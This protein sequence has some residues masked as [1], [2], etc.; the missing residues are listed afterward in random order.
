MPEIISAI[1]FPDR[2]IQDQSFLDADAAAGQ[3]VV[4]VND[5][6][7]WAVNDY[8]VIGTLGQE[9]A[10]L[11][12]V[13]SKSG[14]NV[15]LADNLI[16]KHF[17]NEPATRL[18][19]NQ[20]NFYAALAPLDNTPPA[21]AA[22]TLIDGPTDITAD[23]SFTNFTYTLGGSA[24]WYKYVFFNEEQGTAGALVDAEAVRGGNFGH[25]TTPEAVRK[26]AGLTGNTYIDNGEIMEAIEDAEGTIKASIAIGGYALPLRDD[27]AY[28]LA[29]K[30]T[31][32]MAAGY[33]LTSNNTNGYADVYKQGQDKMKQAQDICDAFEAGTV[34]LLD[35]LD[36]VADKVPGGDSVSGPSS[37]FNCSTPPDISDSPPSSPGN[38]DCN[39]IWF[40]RNTKL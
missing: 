36:Q 30:A 22:Y 10:Q 28:N 40:G 3:A 39:D 33:L 5:P 18:F 26:E 38:D 34:V 27:R 9:N 7:R 11:T 14:Q 24:Y 23:E 21:D 16:V 35:S 2:N 17:I 8:V 12:Q 31:K 25:L 4:V 32:L 6:T 20:V 13:L 19:G 37:D 29:R 15:T 1:N